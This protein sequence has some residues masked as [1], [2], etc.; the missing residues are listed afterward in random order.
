HSPFTQKGSYS[1]LPVLIELMAME[2]TRAVPSARR[3]RTD[4]PWGLES[5]LRKCLMPDPDQRYQQ[6]SHLATDLRRFLEDQPLKHA[7]ELSGV[8]QVEKWVRR[9]PRLTSSMTV[10]LFAAV[11]L[12]GVTVSLMGIRQH[13]AATQAQLVAAQAE[14]RRRAFEEWTQRAV[15]LV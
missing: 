5:I 13:L 12:A 15:C 6:A 11:V 9:H 1:A 7:P 3:L 8:E 14:A 10:A 2:R 4:V